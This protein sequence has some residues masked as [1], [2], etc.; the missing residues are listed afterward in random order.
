MTPDLETIMRLITA[1]ETVAGVLQRIGPGGV[2]MLTL[3]GPAV[4]LLAVLGIDYLRGR[5]IARINEE[6]R[7]ENRKTLEA[8]RRDTQSVLRELGGNQAQ[9]IQFYRD[10]VELVKRYESLAGD[11]VAVVTCN[12]RALERLSVIIEARREGR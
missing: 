5:Q 1:L 11:L 2:V 9:V 4:V 7:A 12:T 6:M 8:Y 10:N 3:A